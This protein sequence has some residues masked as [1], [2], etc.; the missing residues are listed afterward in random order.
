M[1]NS[2]DEY[3]EKN[4]STLAVSVSINLSIKL[5]F[6]SVNGPLTLW[7]RYVY[8]VLYVVGFYETF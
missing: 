2:R 6:V 5:V 3:V 4:S 7:T 1:T 8:T